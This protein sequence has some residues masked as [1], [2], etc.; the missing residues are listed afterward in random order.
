[1]G[2]DQLNS[3]LARGDWQ[4]AQAILAPLT[5]GAGA[6]P[7]LIY[8]HGKVLMELGRH[9]EA[10]DC[11]TRSL[12]SAPDHAAAWFELGRAA[13]EVGDMATAL[14]GFDHAL[15]LDP[16]DL[17]ARRNLG[18]VALRLGRYEAARAAWMAVQDDPEA[19]LALYRIACETGD[20]EAPN[21][22]RALLDTHP[23][24]A[25]VLRALVRVSKG[26]IPLNL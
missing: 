25:A 2:L 22:R 26:A 5:Q 15:T 13:V 8:N 3:A 21:L 14:T 4:S 10:I 11:F 20:Q 7:S 19:R 9:A 1:M 6:H 18:R 12:T 23:D 24:R 17:D 16:S